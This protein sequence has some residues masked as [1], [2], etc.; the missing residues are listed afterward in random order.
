MGTVLRKRRLEPLNG[1]ALVSDEGEVWCPARI[2]R[3]FWVAAD[4]VGVT[5]DKVNFHQTYVGG[6]LAAE[7]L[8]T[9]S[10]WPWRCRAY[11]AYR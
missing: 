5:P 3:A 10:V 7:R 6:A 1:T 8:R 9:M 11:P 4:E 2:L